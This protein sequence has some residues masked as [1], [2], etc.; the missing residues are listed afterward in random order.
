MKS[1]AVGASSGKFL[2]LSSRVWHHL[3]PEICPQWGLCKEENAQFSAVDRLLA[4]RYRAESPASEDRMSRLHGEFERHLA[5]NRFLTES[6]C[7][8]ISSFRK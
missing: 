5:E 4:Q 8:I 2:L 7:S 6:V 3:L 1:A